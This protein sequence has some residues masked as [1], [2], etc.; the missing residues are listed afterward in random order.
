M[1]DMYGKTIVL[2]PSIKIDDIPLEHNDH[3]FYDCYEPRCLKSLCE[4]SEDHDFWTSE[5]D[6]SACP[7][8]QAGQL[9][10]EHKNRCPECDRLIQKEVATLLGKSLQQTEKQLM[11][12]WDDE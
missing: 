10:H 2:K 7:Y 6:W 8:I 5:K 11:N 4:C 3:T 1:I 9:K 12:D